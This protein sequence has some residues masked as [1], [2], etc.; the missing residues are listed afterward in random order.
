VS[1]ILVSRTG[2]VYA[3]TTNGAMHDLTSEFHG[4]IKKPL[5]P[6]QE[7]RYVECTSRG[8]A[9][10][11]LGTNKSI[12]TFTAVDVLKAA[13]LSMDGKTVV[14]GDRFGQ[15]HTLAHLEP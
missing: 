11:E 4:A 13:I 2:H 3:V 1:S 15:L 7:E 6:E 14:A 9:I 10:R 12:T 5:I 8:I